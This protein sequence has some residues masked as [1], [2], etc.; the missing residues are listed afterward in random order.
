[1]QRLY[2]EPSDDDIGDFLVELVVLLAGGWL[3]EVSYGFR[4][5]DSWVP[6]VLLYRV[7]SAGNLVADTRSGGVIAGVDISEAT[8]YSYLKKTSAWSDL[9]STQREA[10]ESTIPVSRQPANEPGV[11][12]GYWVDSDRS[13][14]SGG[15]GM[16]RRTLKP[17]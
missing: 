5:H 11:S 7:N 13:Y 15:V 9:S 3:D 12:G 2:G 8:W 17:L 14:S 4:R 6:P 10:V 16:V 1:M